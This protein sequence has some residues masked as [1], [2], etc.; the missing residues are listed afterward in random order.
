MSAIRVRP[1]AGVQYSAS[2]STATL[3]VSRPTLFPVWTNGKVAY[4]RDSHITA[5]IGIPGLG[6]F[7]ANGSH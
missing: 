1:V 4:W 7:S 2:P 6:M 3:S 5:L